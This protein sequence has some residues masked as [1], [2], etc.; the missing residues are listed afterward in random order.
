MENEIT[1]FK[2]ATLGE[3]RTI[4]SWLVPM[5]C[6]ADVCRIMGLDNPSYVKERLN[7]K[8]VFKCYSHTAGGPQLMT[9]IN[10]PNLYKCIFSSRKPEAIAFQNWVCYDILP[11]IRSTGAFNIHQANDKLKEENEKL[12]EENALLLSTDGQ[13][14]HKAITMQT[15][16]NL[17]STYT[18]TSIGRTRLF[19]LLRKWNYI[20]DNSTLPYQKFIDRGLFEVR[21][22]DSD[23]LCA[24]VTERGQRIIARRYRRSLPAPKFSKL[25]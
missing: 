15:F 17:L 7:P 9:Y 14:S 1:I 13:I 10:E 19:S 11:T 16:A 12:K 2:N 18:G 5:F 20:M 24:L 23:E 3:I 6:L 21:V 25:F 8:G 4:G 22:N